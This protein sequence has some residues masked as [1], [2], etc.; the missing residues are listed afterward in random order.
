MEFMEA[1]VKG[2]EE[3]RLHENVRPHNNNGIT[4]TVDVPC[5]DPNKSLQHG[6]G[7][8]N[9]SGNNSCSGKLS[10]FLCGDD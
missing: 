10:E 3:K 2:G 5:Y 4:S 1:Y 9:S 7:K 6:S 8:N